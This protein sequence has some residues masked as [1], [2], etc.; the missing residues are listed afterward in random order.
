M[1]FRQ[2][3]NTICHLESISISSGFRVKP[4]MKP[5]DYG[6]IDCRGNNNSFK[7]EIIPAR[8]TFLVVRGGLNDKTGWDHCKKKQTGSD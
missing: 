5:K 6:D 2:L 4:G 7:G 8:S 1:L 3:N